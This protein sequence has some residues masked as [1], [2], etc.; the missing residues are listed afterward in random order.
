MK[1]LNLIQTKRK[2]ILIKRLIKIE[3]SLNKET[4]SKYENIETDKLAYASLSG[5][6][7]A[8]S[9]LEHNTNSLFNM[10]ILPFLYPFSM[11]GFNND[12]GKQ[13]LEDILNKTKEEYE[14]ES[15]KDV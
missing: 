12:Y 4:F 3:T 15:N 5:E 7:F 8:K 6:L 11:F 1:I 10:F 2:Q 13:L 14:Q 9:S